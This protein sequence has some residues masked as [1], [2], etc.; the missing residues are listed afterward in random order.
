LVLVH[1]ELTLEEGAV[2]VGERLKAARLE[3]GTRVVVL[4]L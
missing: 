2:G 1:V 3:I 4:M